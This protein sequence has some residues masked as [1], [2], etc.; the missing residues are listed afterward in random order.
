[1][2]YKLRKI[3]E[4]FIITSDKKYEGERCKTLEEYYSKVYSIDCGNTEE[5]IIAQEPNIDFSA[6][7]KEEKMVIG[8]LDVQKITNEYINDRYNNC[9]NKLHFND[10][11]CEID[12]KAGFQKA[13][14]LSDRRFTE[15][16]MEMAVCFGIALE[17]LKVGDGRIS[18]TEEFKGFI[19]QISQQSWT[20]ELE[21]ELYDPYDPRSKT[22]R[23]YGE[24]E[25]VVK[26]T[27]GKVK[28]LKLL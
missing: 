22:G 17:R 4:D 5:I 19:Q 9:D 27:D 13:Q 2:N 23:H 8:W 10:R 11:S 1:M 16:E 15:N 3:K 25:V 12:F 24:H 18:D 26:I 21:M 6:L 20:V 28:I 7:K 14:A